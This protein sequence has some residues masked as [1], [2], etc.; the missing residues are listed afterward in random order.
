M[1]FVHIFL[2]VLMPEDPHLGEELAVGSYL[3]PNGGS[4]NL[5]TGVSTH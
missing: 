2:A 5:H 1:F 3:D 4:G